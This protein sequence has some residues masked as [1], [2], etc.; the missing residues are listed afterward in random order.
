MQKAV[1]EQ[2]YANTF[3]TYL[4]EQLRVPAERILTACG[5]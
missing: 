1:D 5:G 3:K 4:I 2:P